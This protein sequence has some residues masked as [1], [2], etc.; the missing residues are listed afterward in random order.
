MTSNDFDNLINLDTSVPIWDRFF[1]VAPIVLIGTRES[2]GRENLAP[3]HMAAPMGWENYFGFVCTPRHN[4]Y[5]NI[6]REQVFTV[7]F[8]RPSQ[9]LLS[10]LAASPRWEDGSKPQYQELETFL[11]NTIDGPMLK[12]AYLYFECRHH[13]TIDGFG[14]N[15]LVT[16]QITAAYVREDA[17]RQVD[18]D[19]AQLIFN[20]PLLAFLDPGRFTIIKDSFAF[21]YPKDMKR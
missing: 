15:S 12:D 21:P 10:S 3:K 6:Q 4:T 5:H 13:I 11:A 20:A 1:T 2:D 8:P 9:I 16:G 7:S 17:L 18:Y 19:D 14:E